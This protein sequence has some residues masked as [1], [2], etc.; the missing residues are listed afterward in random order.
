MLRKAVT[1]LLLFT[2]VNTTFF[3]EENSELAL[4]FQKEEINSFLE[5]IDEV[6]MGNHDITPEDE[7]DDIP[8]PLKHGKAFDWLSC[9]IYSCHKSKYLLSKSLIGEYCPLFPEDALI[10]IPLLP[11]ELS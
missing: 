11:P 1:Y 3:P 4:N 2:L 7:D 10:E 6:F 9:S 8:D 5:F